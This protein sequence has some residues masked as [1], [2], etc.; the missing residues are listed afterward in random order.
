M[1]SPT[2][3]TERGPLFVGKCA[4]GVGDI[5][6]VEV[7]HSSVISINPATNSAFTDKEWTALGPGS[8]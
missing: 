6:A 5:N 4:S 1:G 2:T 8:G 3:W 7:G